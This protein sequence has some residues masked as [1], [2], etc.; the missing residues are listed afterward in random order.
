MASPSE[1]FQV[2]QRND[3]AENVIFFRS[4]DWLYN[5]TNRT[6]QSVRDEEGQ[7]IIKQFR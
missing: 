7:L 1:I 6:Y 4:Q 5:S 3:Y 2:H